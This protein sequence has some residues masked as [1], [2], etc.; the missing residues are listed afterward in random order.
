MSNIKSFLLYSK[1]FIKNS[2]KIKVIF[3]QL[4][5][6]TLRKSF[7]NFQQSARRLF[8]GICIHNKFSFPFDKNNLFKGN[9]LHL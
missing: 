6:G 2:F 7:E 9:F 1:Y 3:D 4:R 5:H 8:D